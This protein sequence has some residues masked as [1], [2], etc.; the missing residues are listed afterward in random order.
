[1]HGADPRKVRCTYSLAR[2]S[3]R[4]RVLKC[5]SL[6]AQSFDLE[7]RRMTHS[8]RNTEEDCVV[9]RS[10]TSSGTPRDRPPSVQ[11]S[12]PYTAPSDTWNLWPGCIPLVAPKSTGLTHNPS[13]VACAPWRK[14]LRRNS[15]SGLVR[16]SSATHRLR[17]LSLAHF[18]RTLRRYKSERVRDVASSSWLC[19]VAKPGNYTDERCWRPKP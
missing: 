12:E 1:L 15:S 5:C 11:S 6:R 9:A 3:R 8:L 2:S 7:R 4:C 19:R 17:A 14:S 18:P 13:N 10:S 16:V